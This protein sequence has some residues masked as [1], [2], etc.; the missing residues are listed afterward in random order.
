MAEA[1]RKEVFDV[2]IDSLWAEITDYENYPEF[3]DNL[4]DTEVLSRK[5]NTAQVEYQ[6]SMMMKTV[7]YTLEHKETPKTSVEWKQVEGDFFKRNDG[8]WKLREL[9]PAQ[10]EVE[11]TVKVEMPSWVPK[12]VVDMAVNSNLPDMLAAFEERAYN[13]MKK[14]KKTAKKKVVK[15][16][17]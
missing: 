6:I 1:K 12:K 9:G 2:D 10:V 17:K 3:I 11:Y 8:S 7:S 5:G 4:D 13:R 14:G 16:K 15:K